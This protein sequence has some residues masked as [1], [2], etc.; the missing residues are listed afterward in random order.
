MSGSLIERETIPN[1]DLSTSYSFILCFGL[2]MYI[3]IYA[4]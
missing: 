3:Y 2:S 1:A 4:S